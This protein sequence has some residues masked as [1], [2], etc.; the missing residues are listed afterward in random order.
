VICGKLT[1]EEV[2]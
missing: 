2:T 1:D